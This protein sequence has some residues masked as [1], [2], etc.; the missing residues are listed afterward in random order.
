M[1]REDKQRKNT[2]A[3]GMRALQDDRSMRGSPGTA[4]SDH[5]L[6]LLMLRLARPAC[7]WRI[8]QNCSRYFSTPYRDD[9]FDFGDYS[10]ILPPE[11]Y[12]FGVSHIVPRSVPSNIVRPHYALL[13]CSND[14]ETG[15]DD[16][17]IAL[18]GEAEFHLREAAKLA[19]KVREYARSLVKVHANLSDYDRLN[20]FE[21][22][23]LLQIA[24]TPPYTTLFS[25]ILPTLPHFTTQ[26][27]LVRVVPGG[28]A[29]VAESQLLLTLLY[30]INNIIVHGIP[31]E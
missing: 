1:G 30:S 15:K 4:D 16:G 22:L 5:V 14:T 13:G 12:I 11:P 6:S 8:A 2:K 7:R 20:W 29:K 18:G 21:R 23:A 28:W 19:K 24:L 17:K 3:A 10:V 25:R 9:D 31:D 27:T 26:N